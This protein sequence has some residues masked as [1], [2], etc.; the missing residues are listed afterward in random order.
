MKICEPALFELIKDVLTGAPVYALRAPD[1]AQG[2]FIIYQRTDSE[3]W[4][5]INGP[6]GIAQAWIMI[7]CYAE[8]Y[9]TAKQMGTDIE[10]ILD[11]YR[12]TVLYGDN[13]PQDSVVICGI[14]LQNDEDLL[15][16]TD[17]PVLF[18]HSASY[19]V[20]YKQED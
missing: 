17:E 10:A 3:R 12:G 8:K 9:F 15:D 7:D 19:L 11:G 20:T 2:P 1:G 5:S 4:R 6:S 16:Q 13:S 18:R 14:S